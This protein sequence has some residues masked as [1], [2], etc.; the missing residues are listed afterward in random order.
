MPGSFQSL[1]TLVNRFLPLFSRCFLVDRR[2]CLL[3]QS[4]HLFCCCSPSEKV[5][6]TEIRRRVRIVFHAT[7]TWWRS[8]MSAFVLIL[9]LCGFA[10][11]PR[12]SCCLGSGAIILMSYKGER[13]GYE[14]RERA[15]QQLCSCNGIGYKLW[16]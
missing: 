8:A 4:H 14:P 5:C 13:I 3:I 11:Y 15:V 12:S 10:Q 7:D 1:T 9:P 6:L 16:L 2:R